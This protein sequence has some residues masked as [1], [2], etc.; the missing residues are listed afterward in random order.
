MHNT[1][2]PVVTRAGGNW[3]AVGSLFSGV[4]LLPLQYTPVDHD[5]HRQ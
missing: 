3:L 1:G 2:L 5:A 4:D